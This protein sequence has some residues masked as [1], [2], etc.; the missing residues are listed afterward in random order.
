MDTSTALKWAVV[1]GGF[2]SYFLADGCTYSAGILF[3]E[4]KD[5]FKASATA[6]SLLP[7][8]IYAI[9]QFM[10][11]LICPVTNSVGYSTA[12]A[13][14]AIFLCLSFIV[15]SFAQE[16][17]ITYFAYG[18]LMSLGLQMTYTSA[19]M[20]VCATF[21]DS[22]WFGLACGI[23]TCGGGIG[24]FVTNHMLIWVLS[25][26][27]WRETLVIQGG[28]FLHAWISAAIFYWSDERTAME[29]EAARY[30]V[31][32]EKDEQSD[33]G[34]ASV[35]GSA[36]CSEPTVEVDQPKRPFCSRLVDRLK[37]LW[38][39]CPIIMILTP[40]QQRPRARR[41]EYSMLV[42]EKDSR[43]QWKEFHQQLKESFSCLFTKSVW[44]NAPFLIYVLTNGMAAASVVIPWT[45]VY[46]YV[47][48]E[49][50]SGSDLNTELSSVA[51][52]QLAWYPSLIGLGSCAGQILLGLLISK[53]HN[54]SEVKNKRKVNS[55]MFVFAAVLFMNGAMTLVFTL[56]PLP[57][58]L[59]SLGVSGTET[60]DLFSTTV[61]SVFAAICFFLGMTDGAFM[62][63]L[64]PMLELFLNETNFPAGLGISL[65]FTG[66]FN[67]AGTLL[68]G[69]M[70]DAFG[71]YYSANLFAAVLTFSGFVVFIIFCF[72]YYRGE[73]DSGQ[74]SID[75][76]EVQ[77]NRL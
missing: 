28:F 39:L 52:T 31:Y 16:I 10:S 48:S 60:A 24:A 34:K 13:W 23:M 41:S 46:D 38:Y 22:K 70:L 30:E 36:D 64:G 17:G 74:T 1:L 62:T 26:W 44:T 65:F 49:W 63:I 61:G 9:P 75:T 7:A 59:S 5:I 51:E 43:S 71:S 21:K 18:V 57:T 2:L 56:A 25:L 55:L 33:G 58:Y 54:P 47:R 6:T 20:A 50:L 29:N 69:H 32:L 53:V 45:F 27:T 15:T 73:K 72:I 77:T 8:L 42:I 67:L 76:T 35:E 40:V 14:G 11:P 66:A 37:N 19:F 4:F 68:G 3:A 12:A